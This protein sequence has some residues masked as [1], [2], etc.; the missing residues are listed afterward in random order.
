MELFFDLVYVFAFTQLSDNLYDHPTLI[1]GLQTAVLFL[2]LWWAWDH[3]AWATGLIDPERPPVVALL[4]VLMAIS[5]VMS[6]TIL[7]AF[8]DRGEG[9]AIAYV[10][11][12]LLRA[13]F[14]VWAFG[15]GT[16]MG[17]NYA[18][19]LA[20]AA[21]A[22][23]VWIAGGLVEDPDVRLAIW[24]VAVALDYGVP[25]VGFRLPGVAPI[26]IDDWTVASEHL[27]ERCQQVL[28]VAFG[29]TMLRI[30]AAYAQRGDVAGVNAA[31]IV[32]F[33]LIFALWTIY[34]LYHPKRHAATIGALVGDAARIG[35]TVYTY[36][37]AVMV[38]AVIV[39]ADAIHLAVEA[40]G[41]SVS[42][43][44][45]VLCLGGPALYLIGVAMAKLWPGHSRSWPPVVGAAG[46]LVVGIPAALGTRLTELIAATAVVVALSVVAARD[47]AAALPRP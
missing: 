34:F 20:W 24:V 45:S 21:I 35:Q 1:G 18:R 44:F 10:S 5:L 9:F 14:M 16:N 40:P 42:V 29:E 7:T 43:D 36:A 23:L 8:E 28:M 47:S 30:G 37:H 39:V 12:Q 46:L 17:R 27:A 32:G 19:M 26:P 33:I 11:L 25:L 4:A 3:T 15:W 6:A 2:A 31:F 41:D 13:G 38:G 22:G